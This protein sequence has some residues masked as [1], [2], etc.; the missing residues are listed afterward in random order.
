MGS[1]KFLKQE[2]WMHY[3]VNSLLI[4][5]EQIR[6]ISRLGWL[7]G[8]LQHD[9]WAAFLYFLYTQFGFNLWSFAFIP[10]HK[11]TYLKD[12]LG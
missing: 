9:M 12:M 5:G 4:R 3:L 2:I 6:E 7:M 8:I 11:K 1:V 10:D